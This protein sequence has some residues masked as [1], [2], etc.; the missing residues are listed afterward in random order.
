MS[1]EVI[2]VAAG[3]GRRFGGDVPKQ[4]LPLG[5]EP[6][7]AH[8][9]RRFDSHPEV[10]RIVVVVEDEAEF[11]GRVGSPPPFAKVSRVVRGGKERQDSVA[12]GFRYIDPASVVLVHDAARPLV[13][14]GLITAVIAAATR[15]GAAIPV[16]PVPDT[17]KLLDAGGGLEK[18]L[19]R[20][21]V[22]LAQTPQGFHAAVLRRALEA[23][24]RDRFRG[25]DEAALVE[26]IGHPVAIVAG[27]PENIK[28]TTPDDLD[29]ARTML[30]D[31]GAGEPTATPRPG[32]RLRTGI[33]FDQHPLVDGRRLV[34]GGVE[35]PFGRGLDGHSDADVLVHA[36]C[37]ALLGAAGLGDIGRMFPDT[38]AK[39]H[40]A[41]SL[42]FL[43]A[44]GRLLEEK[45]FRIANL[46]VTLVAEEPMIGPFR[47]QMR[48][49]LATALGCRREAVSVK[50]SRSGGLGPVGRGEG[51]AAWCSALL[52]TVA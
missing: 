48:Q 42:E 46:D 52:E 24:A 51:M 2:V 35:V 28:I 22:A 34:L 1:V 5:G 41:R 31:S 27:R 47:E 19:D 8:G 30:Q 6:L 33:G 3:Q 17:P 20:D 14:A 49:N 23:A 32:P 39:H 21:R 16:V 43:A 45:G 4:Y 50:A 36:V 29:R 11:A 18:T 40:G 38:D 13:G 10:D 15:T 12:A 7:V 26:R 25:T 37:D 44:V 9:L